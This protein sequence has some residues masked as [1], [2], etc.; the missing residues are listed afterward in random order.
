MSEQDYEKK[1][2]LTRK[3]RGEIRR[4][5]TGRHK[6]ARNKLI[7]AKR[8][9]LSTLPAVI[10]FLIVYGIIQVDIP[11]KISS[12]AR[13]ISND[14]Q[15]VLT[16]AK[17]AVPRSKKAVE[18]G[19]IKSDGKNGTGLR[20]VGKGIESCL[21]VGTRGVGKSEEAVGIFILV[22]DRI[23]NEI[24]A[25]SIPANVFVNVPGYGYDKLALAQRM[26]GIEKT[27][28]AVKNFLS[29]PI[30]HYVKIR[31]QDF[32]KLALSDGFSEM[33]AKA[34]A[35]DM[36]SQERI[37]F[38]YRITKINPERVEVE[39]LP[40]KKMDV[41]T[42]VYFE[43]S[44]E[45]TDFLMNNIFNVGEDDRKPVVRVQVLNGC[46][47]PGCTGPVQEKLIEAGFR[48]EESK[49][50]DRFDYEHTIIISYMENID[51]ATRMR[52]VL[53]KGTVV[54]KKGPQE[55]IDVIV[56]IGRDLGQGL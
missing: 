26:G 7:L 31:N 14:T 18:T 43:V 42:D 30:D 8:I 24:S 56:V 45:Q 20:A 44:K 36:N 16:I 38:A 2:L 37:D 12:Y 50:A 19:A 4:R 21:I 13:N 39:S 29:V 10:L 33:V 49:N 40:G 17:K 32:E 34:V 55:L 1:Y 3:D 53:G 27:V 11:G 15:K 25:V 6:A 54:Q 48:V 41:G 9:A 5:Q 52:R 23:D 22:I 47:T 51:E 35:T 46:G 28:L